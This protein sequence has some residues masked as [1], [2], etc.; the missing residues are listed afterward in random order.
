MAKFEILHKSLKKDA[1]VQSATAVAN[2][3]EQQP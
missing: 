2:L 1:D 3:L